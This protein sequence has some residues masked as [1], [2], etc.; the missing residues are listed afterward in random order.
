VPSQR[1]R[2]L[3]G[4]RALYGAAT[5]DG[6]GALPAFTPGTLGELRSLAA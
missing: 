1:R 3:A 2:M 6:S 5:G 4:A